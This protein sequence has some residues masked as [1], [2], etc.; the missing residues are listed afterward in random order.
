MRREDWIKGWIEVVKERGNQSRKPLSESE[1][2]DMIYKTCLVFE[3]RL[4]VLETH[5]GI[6]YVSATDCEEE[7]DV[8]NEK[9]SIRRMYVIKHRKEEI[10]FY[11]SLKK[12]L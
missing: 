4:L 3:K 8:N 11:R 12:I 9:V 5:L 6:K 10:S 1:K 7:D 2:I